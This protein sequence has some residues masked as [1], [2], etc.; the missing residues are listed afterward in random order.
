MHISLY[1][2]LLTINNLSKRKKKFQAGYREVMDFARIGSKDTYYKHLE[3]LCDMGLVECQKG[4]NQWMEATFSLPVL[5]QN[6]GKQKESSEEPTPESTGNIKS[7]SLIV[8]NPIVN[9]STP[10]PPDVP[11]DDVP[12]QANKN[13]NALNVDMALL[14]TF[15]FMQSKIKNE[16][17]NI[18]KVRDQITLPEYIK[19]RDKYSFEA[20]WILDMLDEM[21]NTKG[22]AKY[23]SVYKTILNWLK[24]EHS[25]GK[26][27]RECTEKFKIRYTAFLVK[28]QDDSEAKPKMD[29]YEKRALKKIITHL[30]DTSHSKD[31]AGA[32]KSW[33]AI[34]TLWGELD[35]FH[36]NRL[37]LS[38]ID[39]SLPNII[40]QIRNAAKNKPK[41]KGT[42][43]NGSKNY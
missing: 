4:K 3:Q 32:L 20:E 29:I 28:E 42:D 15:Q 36:Q 25:G 26:E 21:D 18:Q 5:Y 35:V 23:N 12:A 38:D 16:C 17:P 6:I 9:N 11:V 34:L 43:N 41:R 13:S 14:T 27:E 7:N 24:K 1:M 22:I 10:P 8:D 33:D 37:R 30:Q 39:K 2:A 31:F 19:L 40:K